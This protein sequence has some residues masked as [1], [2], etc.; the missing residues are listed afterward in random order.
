MTEI[1]PE[2]SGQ[3]TQFTALQQRA[4][5]VSRRLGAVHPDSVGLGKCNRHYIPFK[6]L[7]N[8][9]Y[10]CLHTHMPAALQIGDHGHS[11]R[12]YVLCMWLC[13]RTQF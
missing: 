7:I 6:R 13:A 10:R 3:G 9:M 2:N 8:T 11:C 5:L 1:L 12:V 4:L